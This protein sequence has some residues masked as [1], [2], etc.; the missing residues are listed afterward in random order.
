MLQRVQSPRTPM[1]FSKGNWFDS[2]HQKMWC[3]WFIFGRSSRAKLIFA[4]LAENNHP[5]GSFEKRTLLNI[6]RATLLACYWSEWTLNQFYSARYSRV[7]SDAPADGPPDRFDPFSETNHGRNS[8][9]E[10]RT[11]LRKIRATFQSHQRDDKSNGSQRFGRWE[12]KRLIEAWRFKPGM[13]VSLMKLK[14]GKKW[15]QFHPFLWF[16]HLKIF[17]FII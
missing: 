9:T 17:I 1:R 7:A 2:N 10:K 16:Q 12:V 5:S 3:M 6:L 8:E 11:L 15:N 13:K 4:N 14:A